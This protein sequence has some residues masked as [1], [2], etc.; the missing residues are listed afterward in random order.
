[1]YNYCEIATWRTPG[2]FLIT[3]GQNVKLLNPMAEILAAAHESLAIGTN[4]AHSD[5]A[6]SR[7]A[8]V[9]IYIT[10]KCASF[11]ECILL[12]EICNAISYNK[13]AA[14]TSL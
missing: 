3:P 10:H 9:S 14:L 11:T 4:W 1:M 7:M 13:K 12:Y 5:M 6:L 8:S 2:L